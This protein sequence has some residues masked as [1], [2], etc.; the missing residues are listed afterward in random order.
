MKM[1]VLASAVTVAAVLLTTMSTDAQQGTNATIK[2]E[3]DHI[4]FLV[5]NDLVTRYHI[6]DDQPLPYFWPVNAPGGT[7]TTR[8]WPMDKDLPEK[9]KDHPHH[10]SVWF[11]HGDVIPEGMKFKSKK[12]IQGVDF[13]SETKGTGG[14]IVCVKV[15]QPQ[16]S[17]DGPFITTQNEWR[18]PEGDK[19]MDETRKITLCNLGKANLLI[20]DIDLSASVCPITFADTKEGTMAI[21]IHSDIATEQGLGGKIQNAEGKINEK[22]TWGYKSA[23]CDYSGKV[24]GKMVGLAV[25]D[26]PTNPYP[27]CWHARGYGLMAANPFGRDKHS[28]FPAMKGN[29]TPVRLAKGEHVHLR[30]GILLHTGDAIDGQVE[31]GFKRFVKM[32]ESEKK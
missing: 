1:I 5:G 20:L 18:L 15:E 14:K 25:L 26:D 29:D 30:Y 23:W 19:I 3:K 7:P 9:K 21:R 6:K 24:D 12:G 28:K 11:A 31:A 22:E 8:A 13:W 2:L 27:A 32:R 4:D 17:P 10:H 16:K